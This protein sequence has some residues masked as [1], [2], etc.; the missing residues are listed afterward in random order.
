LIL[1]VPLL[2]GACFVGAS[3]EVH[4]VALAPFPGEP[5]VVTFDEALSPYGTWIVIEPYGRAW[6]PSAAVVGVDFVPYATGGEWVYTDAGWCFET[7][8]EWGWAPFHYGRWY[9][10]AEYG[11][12]WIPGTTWAAAWVDWRVSDEY[13][14]WVPLPPIGVEIG[15]SYWVF[16]GPRDF[17]RPHVIAYALPRERSYVAYR[18]SAPVREVIV[19]EGVSW[20]AGPAPRRVEVA[21][22]TFMRPVHVAMPASGAVHRTQTRPVRG[23]APYVGSPPPRDQRR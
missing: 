16:V 12:V 18:A 14:G 7:Y 23:A 5:T 13:I 20:S 15:A 1:A 8:W 21:T 9:H 6:R 10:G 4:A 19:R 11:W 17:V 22:G 3:T 2:N